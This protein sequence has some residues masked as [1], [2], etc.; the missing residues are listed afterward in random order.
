MPIARAAHFSISVTLPLR[1]EPIRKASQWS[2]SA[3][4]ANSEAR[5]RICRN[6]AS[7][8]SPQAISCRKPAKTAPSMLRESGRTAVQCMNQSLVVL[9]RIVP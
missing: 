9:R 1:P 3:F 5:R 8:A 7:P 4:D 6:L 2:S